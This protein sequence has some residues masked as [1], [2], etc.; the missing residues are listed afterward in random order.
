MLGSRWISGLGRTL[1]PLISP[2]GSNPRL[3]ILIY[4]RVLPQRDF[5]FHGEVDA[6]AFDDQVCLLKACFNIIPLGDAVKGIEHGN[7]PPRAA[8]ITFDD[9]YADNAEVA[10][11]ILKKHHAPATFF[12]ATGF[13]DGGRMWND[14]VIE[15]VRGAC[16]PML[17]LR[18]CGL[19]VFDIGTLEQR[20]ETIANLLGALKYLPLGARQA[21]IGH[22][23][24]IVRVPL[25][26]NLMMTS[27]QVNTLHNAGME[28]GAHTVNHPI[29]A[30]LDDTAARNEI[31]GGKEAL[32]GLTR[33]PV[34]LFAYPNG[35][36]GQDYLPSHVRMV[37]ELR[38]SGAVSTAWGGARAGCDRYQLPRFTPW[39][40]HKLKFMLRLAQN[41]LKGA[42]TA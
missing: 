5:L 2:G 38:F 17:D 10:L 26:D 32:E 30:R 16:G 22:M 8:C 28:I 40:R 1:M 6:Q 24:D 13:L 3:A 9:G 21:R 12:V 42:Q 14:T 7:L 4:H 37:R 35:K 18:A 27:T 20:R 25:P 19:G 34:R 33:A 41:M 31:G 29:L 39:D 23:C 15:L 36:P 11:P